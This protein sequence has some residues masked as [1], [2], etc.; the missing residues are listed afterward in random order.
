ME[1][2]SRRAA[3]LTVSETDDSGENFASYEVRAFLCLSPFMHLA[4]LFKYLQF[5]A[6]E[7]Y[8]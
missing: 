8:R 3:L 5:V 6:V 7:Q 2:N 4:M 1:F